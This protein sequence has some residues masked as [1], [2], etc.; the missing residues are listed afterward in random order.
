MALSELKNMLKSSS[1]RSV[2]HICEP[3]NLDLFNGFV[4]DYGNSIANAYTG[5]TVI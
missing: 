3:R 2:M 1:Q 5:G 4:Q